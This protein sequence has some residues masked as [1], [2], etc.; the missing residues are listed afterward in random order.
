[1]SKTFAVISIY[2]QQGFAGIPTYYEFREKLQTKASKNPGFPKHA[3]LGL[4]LK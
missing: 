3:L 2:K 1:M 4:C